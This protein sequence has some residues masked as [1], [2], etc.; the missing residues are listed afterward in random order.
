MIAAGRIWWAL[1]LLTL[2]LAPLPFASENT[3]WSMPLAIVCFVLGVSGALGGPLL[4]GEP[5]RVPLV[6]L[7]LAAFSVWALLQSVVLPVGWA[8]A[9]SP[10]LGRLPAL[11]D[12]SQ[13]RTLSVYPGATLERGLLL[14]GLS[15]LFWAMVRADA[16]MCLRVL[17]AA[18]VAHALL[19]IGLAVTGGTGINQGTTSVLFV[20]RID[21]V[22]TPFGTYV[23]K[24]HFA[25]LMVI[26]GGGC[27][28]VLL[29][30]LQ[31]ARR[32]L[33][34]VGIRALIGTLTGR[35]FSRVV[36][37]GIGLAAI[38]LAMWASGS[39][40]AV[41]A[42]V[43]GFALVVFSS[44]LLLR[45]SFMKYLVLGLAVFGVFA[46]AATLAPSISVLERLLPE[47]RYLNRPRLWKD[48]V[49]MSFRYPLAGTGGGTFPYIY[50]RYQSFA[51]DRE[52]THAEG[53]WVQALSESGAV[54][55]AALLALFVVLV[56]GWARDMRK[57]PSR[58]GLLMGAGVGVLAIVLHGMV[59]VSLHRPAN[60]VA[61]V[62]LLG[63][64]VG[65]LRGPSEV[66]E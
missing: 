40:G 44:G 46:A 16:K 25:G 45:R 30:R 60:M 43:T 3:E 57:L 11:P 58:R 41:L 36:L 52:F 20:Y 24:N 33:G 13:L 66:T 14:L 62:V 35:K 42:W 55:A 18:G 15:Y 49:R 7:P 17:A 39:R 9:L 22:L 19:A 56:R 10:E 2:L 64:L 47:G 12:G 37:P 50:P 27:L 54:G 38:S 1:L 29:W 4:R 23:N 5:V 48:V 21:E 63:G 61:A 51:P 59:D 28:A 53:D 32:R 8:V 26:C 34:P 31:H 65:R 6:V